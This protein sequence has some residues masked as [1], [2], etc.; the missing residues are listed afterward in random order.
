[1]KKG[2]NIMNSEEL[3]LINLF[4]I[5]T[6]IKYKNEWRIIIACGKP[7]YH[8]G[9][10]KTDIYILLDNN[11][12]IKIS[13]KKSTADFIQNKI[14]KQQ[15]KILFNDDYSILQNVINVLIP[16]F[17]K[18]PVYY[19]KPFRSIRGHSYTIGYRFDIIN[20]LS[21]E[22]C[23]PLY[24]TNKQKEEIFYGIS[25]PKEKAD[26]CVNGIEIKNCG[27]ANCLLLDSEKYNTP[28]EVIDNLIFVE[29]Y[30]PQL[31]ATFRAVNYRKDED[32]IDGN[33]ALA[34]Y[35]N[36]KNSTDYELIFNEP[37]QH[38]AKEILQHFKDVCNL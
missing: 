27:I 7:Q 26:V 13:S 2:I 5:G 1:M 10:G 4:P 22:L 33:R 14:T 29:D 36:W 38:G 12:E 3:R 17:L 34:V 15:Y 9:E 6:K 18:R 21:G 35:I 32:K 11:E 16:K 30:N 19:D 31:Y 37:L 23:A 8:S 28:Q 20:K 25:L 24:L